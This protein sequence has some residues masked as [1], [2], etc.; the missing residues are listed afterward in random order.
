MLVAQEPRSVAR[1]LAG[2]CLKEVGFQPEN[3][4]PVHLVPLR[5]L[6]LVKVRRLPNLSPREGAVLPLTPQLSLW[7]SEQAR[8]VVG[9]DEAGITSR[10]TYAHELAHWAARLQLPDEV[11][12]A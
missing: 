5:R 6:L 10:F 3:R 7:E 1:Q 2:E 8:L 12:S 11:C 4:R 9:D